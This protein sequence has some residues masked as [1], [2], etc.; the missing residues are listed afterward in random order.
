VTD[1]EVYTDKAVRCGR[2]GESVER[3]QPHPRSQGVATWRHLVPGDHVAEP[4]EGAE[5]HGIRT[6]I[7]GG[8]NVEV[9]CTCR[10]WQGEAPSE[11]SAMRG[12]EKHVEAE[13]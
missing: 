10:Q 5:E 13:K 2:C 4:V 9:W 6:R 3:I 11:R 7:T 12:F 1:H 8:G